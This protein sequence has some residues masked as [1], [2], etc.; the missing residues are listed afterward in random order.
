MRWLRVLGC[1]ALLAHVGCSEG[2]NEADASTSPTPDAP[3]SVVDAPVGNVDAPLGSPDASSIDGMVAQADAMVPDGAV[4]DANV[5]D[6]TVPDAMV[7]D[8]ATGCVELPTTGTLTLNGETTGADPTWLRPL[9]SGSCPA[10]DYS[11]IGTAVPYDTFVLCNNS[12]GT[13][14][15]DF[16]MDG[17]AEGAYT[18]TD[19]YLVLYSGT[20]I[21]A[22]PLQCLDGDDDGSAA[23]NGSLATGVTIAAGA[24]VTVVATGF[25]NTDIGTYAVRVV[26]P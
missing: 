18:H 5:P 15:L 19:P 13:L 3:I 2:K 12:G 25:D 1:A 4:P 14:V 17:A 21:P 11:S 9:A 6:A 20:M 7:P 26:V 16:A 8:A 22:D 10:S 24:S 23:G